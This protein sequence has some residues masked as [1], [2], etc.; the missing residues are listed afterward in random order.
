MCSKCGGDMA[1]FWDESNDY[2]RERERERD[3]EDQEEN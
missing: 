3:N 2:A 1:H